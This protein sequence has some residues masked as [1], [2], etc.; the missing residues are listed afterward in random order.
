MV[1]HLTDRVLEVGKELVLHMDAKSTTIT[2]AF[3][4][5]SSSSGAWKLI[6]ASPQLRRRGPRPLYQIV[7]SK[8]LKYNDRP[9]SLSD[10]IF[11]DDRSELVVSLKHA[12]S[13]G[14]NIAGVRFSNNYIG[15]ILFEDLYVYRS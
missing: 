12:I 9:L 5:F 3:W 15:G 11:V 2:S 13:T 14:K 6:F 1:T 4:L 10:V 7:Q 8:L